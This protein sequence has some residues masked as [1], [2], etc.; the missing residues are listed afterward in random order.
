MLHGVLH[1]F[2]LVEKEFLNFLL[3]LLQCD[4]GFI[5]WEIRQFLGLFVE[6]IDFGFDFVEI[7]FDF[8]QIAILIISLMLSMTLLAEL[9]LTVTVFG[10]ANVNERQG[11]MLAERLDLDFLDWEHWVLFIKSILS[12]N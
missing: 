11:V 4:I 9:Y 2:D 3:G 5:R 12:M 10:D 8:H 7:V 1:D 6:N